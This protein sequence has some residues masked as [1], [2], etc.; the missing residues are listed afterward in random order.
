MLILLSL[1]FVEITYGS[2]VVDTKP[3]TGPPTA[4][5][6]NQDMNKHET[7]ENRY[8]NEKSLISFANS[9]KDD[10]LIKD[11]QSCQSNFCAKE[12]EAVTFSVNCKGTDS[13]MIVACIMTDSP[14]GAVFILDERNPAKGI[15]YYLPK[16]AGYYEV[17]FQTKVLYCP[18]DLTECFDNQMRTAQIHVKP[19]CG[20]KQFEYYRG[21][22]DLLPFPKYGSILKGLPAL[23]FWYSATYK[24]MFPKNEDDKIF[25]AY[26]KSD[27]PELQSKHSKHNI[28][29]C[30]SLLRIDVN[31]AFPGNPQAQLNPA[32]IR[33]WYRFTFAL[34]NHEVGHVKIIKEGYY[35]NYEGKWEH[36]GGFNGIIKKVLGLTTERALEEIAKRETQTQQAHDKYDEDTIH[37]TT[38]DPKYSP[39][40]P[41]KLAFFP[42]G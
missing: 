40:G 3:E 37:G 13:N 8:F 7:K 25:W 14:Q 30:D 5:S 19:D 20:D 16:E 4:H 9:S 1:F 24:D 15:F 6:L 21:D 11:P 38:T 41:A 10:S 32:E 31:I 17:S 27:P 23:A 18:P 12:G 29:D 33:E 22:I 2:F 28:I 26:T 34:A 36:K 42:N 39:F 35:G